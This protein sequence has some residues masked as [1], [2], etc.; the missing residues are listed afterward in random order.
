MWLLKHI[1]GRNAVSA[2]K[3]IVVVGQADCL[4]LGAGLR[5]FDVVIALDVG[6]ALDVVIAFVRR[7]VPRRSRPVGEGVS[8]RLM[9]PSFVVVVV[10][11]LFGNRARVRVR[12]PGRRCSCS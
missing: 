4:P 12:R 5:H 6:I 7:S 1:W 3:S 8:L 11:T 9:G 10:I 2:A